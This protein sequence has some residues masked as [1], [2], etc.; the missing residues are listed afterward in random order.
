MD[1][2]RLVEMGFTPLPDWRDAVVRYL[3]EMDV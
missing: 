3:K 2:S 1:K